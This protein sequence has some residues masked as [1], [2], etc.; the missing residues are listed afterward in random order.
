VV[1]TWLLIVLL[2]TG[3]PITAATKA[4][5]HRPTSHGNEDR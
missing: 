4:P 5:A 3:S 2:L 1:A